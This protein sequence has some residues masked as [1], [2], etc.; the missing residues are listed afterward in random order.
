MYLSRHLGRSL[1][2]PDRVSVNVTLRCNLTCAMCTTCYDAPELS[3]AEIKGIIDQ[4]AAWGVEVFNPLGGEPFMRGDIEEI[5]DY[6]VLRGFYV[7]VTTNGTLITE[8]RARAVAAIPADRLHLIFSLDGAAAAH[9]R[10]RGAGM[11]RRAITGYQRI[12]AADTKAGNPRRKI[13]TNTILHAGNLRGFSEVLDEQEALGFDGVQILNLFRTG[14][15]VPPEAAGLWL[16]ERHMPALRTLSVQLSERAAAQSPGAAWRIQNTPEELRLIPRYYTDELGPLEAPC[17]A[18][19]KELYINADGAA[20]MCDGKLDFLAGAFGNVRE[21][22]LRQLWNSPALG[23]RRRVVK[24]C[25]TPCIQQCYLRQESDSA[26]ELA[27]DAAR[28]VSAQVGATIR[29]GLGAIERHPEMTLRLELSDVC[30]CDW[31][32]CDVPRERWGRVIADCPVDVDPAGWGELRDR[33]YLDFGRGFMGFEIVRAVVDDLLSSRIRPGTLAVAWRG[34]PLLHP[35]VEPILRYLMERIARDGLADRLRIDTSGVFSTEGLTALAGHAAPQVWVVDLDRGNGAG[36]EPLRHARGAD[37][38]IIAAV[39]AG[40]D[41]SALA[42]RLPAFTPTV[43]ALPIEGGDALWVRRKEHRHFRAN[44]RARAE[45]AAAAQTLG[46]SAPRD[47]EVGPRR[48]SAPVRSPTVSWDGKV[49]LCPWDPLLE[50]RVGEV[51]AEPLSKIWR[52]AI[53]RRAREAAE[54]GA[55]PAMARCRDC[56]VPWGPNI[57]QG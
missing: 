29:R 30:A 20:I 44:A 33:G 11:W 10:I 7:T 27:S 54:R 1:A 26:R 16:R 56:A 35:E 42:A 8:R 18:G 46:V 37:T 24:S 36:L 45:L 13:L 25:R 57:D 4:V 41:V 32:G 28:I 50:N 47:A 9:D 14:P 48:C 39:H 55:L 21:Q 5:L 31:E 53:W 6:A 23:E 34:E 22:S 17:W 38:R 19:W 49:T 15:E 40:A 51:T 43:G 12:R 2:P 3:T 52:G